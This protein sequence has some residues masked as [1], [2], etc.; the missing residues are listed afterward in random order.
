MTGDLRLTCDQQAKLAPLLHQEESLFRSLRAFA[1][2]TPEQKQ[3][4]LLKVDVAVHTQVRPMLDPG[5]QKKTARKLES[6]MAEEQ[7]PKKIEKHAAR[8]KSSEV[9]ADPYASEEQ[10]SSDIAAFRMLT[11]NDRK[12]MILQ[13]KQAARREG[14]APLGSEQAAKI[15]ADIRKLQE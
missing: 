13:V 4:M 14:V 6:L 7:D 5:Q 9:P 3:A 12:A 8:L 10:L 11:V 15:D 1:A 2:F